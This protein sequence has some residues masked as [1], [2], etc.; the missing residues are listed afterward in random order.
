MSFHYY[1][2]QRVVCVNDKYPPYFCEWCDE[3]PVEGQIYTVKN[4]RVCFDFY[5]KVRGLGLHL[6][7]LKNPERFFYCAQR[8][9]P[10]TSLE[11]EE[12]MEEQLVIA[13]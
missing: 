5:S 3:F 6:V 13:N 10:V 1:P 8:F 12:V 7:E 11:V 9:V 4:V 2:G